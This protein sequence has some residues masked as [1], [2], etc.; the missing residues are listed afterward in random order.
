LWVLCPSIGEPNLVRIRLIFQGVTAFGVFSDLV[1]SRIFRPN[2]A[3]PCLMAYISGTKNLRPLKFGAFIG[4]PDYNR[5]H[6]R[7]RPQR[8][9]CGK[10]APQKS[11]FSQTKQS[12]AGSG[13]KC[14]RG[15]G[16]GLVYV[17]GEPIT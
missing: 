8:P 10:G 12:L 14:F 6:P 13:G 11:K 16:S 9:P 5:S 3:V 17:A 2:N 1:F 4:S 7:H 15:F